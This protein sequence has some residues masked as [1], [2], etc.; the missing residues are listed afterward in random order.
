MELEEFKKE[1]QNIKT[2]NATPDQ[3]KAMTLEKNRPVLN[4]IK[5]QFSLELIGWSVF[6]IVCFTGLDANQKPLLSNAILIISVVLPM[7]L[8]IYGYRLSRELI[9][10]SDISSSLQNRIASLSRFVVASILLRILLIVG[11]GYFFTASIYIDQH[12]LILLGAGSIFVA[13]LL[14]LLVRIWIK[15]ISKLKETLIL[16]KA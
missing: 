9:E 16:L 15:R 2:P 4:G 11:V 12:K 1:W 3:L 14:Y 7:I 8:N 10:G 5:K 6:L 13:F